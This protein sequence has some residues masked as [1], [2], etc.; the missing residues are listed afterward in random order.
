MTF[1]SF[2]VPLLWVLITNKIGNARDLIGVPWSMQEAFQ[3]LL[4]VDFVIGSQ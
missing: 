4:A 2:L 3:F 1:L